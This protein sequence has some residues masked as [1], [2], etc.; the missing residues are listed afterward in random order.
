MNQV[1][2][3]TSLIPI[4]DWMGVSG[5]LLTIASGFYMALTVWGLRTSWILVALASILLIIGPSIGAIVEPRTRRLVK[6]AKKHVDGPVSP[7]LG[8]LIQDPVLGIALHTNL[9]VVLG[10]VFLMTT[11]PALTG[12]IAAMIVALT[13]GAASGFIL[14]L[15][16]EPQR[17]VS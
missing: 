4:T 9:A 13:L 14:W 16:K 7:E 5:S 3:I 10:I 1:K 8:A 17:R 2:M 11:K 12:A 6:M 15:G